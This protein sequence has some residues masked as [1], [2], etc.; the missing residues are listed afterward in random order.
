M[1]SISVELDQHVKSERSR[2]WQINQEQLIRSG[3]G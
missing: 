3:A 2:N 1:Y